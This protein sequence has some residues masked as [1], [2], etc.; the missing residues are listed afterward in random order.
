MSKMLWHL[1]YEYG[2]DHDARSGAHLNAHLAWLSSFERRGLL[3]GGANLDPIASASIFFEGSEALVQEF[4]R[5]DPYFTNGLVKAHH[6][7]SYIAVSG[8]FLH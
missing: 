2:P 8:T 5:G 3:L 4:V 6:I 7:R 1:Q